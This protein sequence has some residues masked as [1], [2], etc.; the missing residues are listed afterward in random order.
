MS[1]FIFRLDERFNFICLSCSGATNTAVVGV[2]MTGC[3]WGF[4]F[5]RVWLCWESLFARSPLLAEAVEALGPCFD[6]ISLPKEN[7]SAWPPFSGAI[8]WSATF[9]SIG[10][11]VGLKIDSEE[12]TWS[13]EK[14]FEETYCFPIRLWEIGRPFFILCDCDCW[15]SVAEWKG[16][17]ASFWIPLACMEASPNT[18]SNLNMD[19]PVVTASLEESIGSSSIFSFSCFSPLSVEDGFWLDCR[20]SLSDL[21][22]M[23]P[24]LYCDI[25]S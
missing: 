20:S 25:F 19:P 23:V 15:I 21:T 1:S 13:A 3:A 22:L 11:N 10:L 4:V 16:S 14:T 24:R 2:L 12:L 5:L 8:V 18:L 7:L 17:I 9:D 6:K